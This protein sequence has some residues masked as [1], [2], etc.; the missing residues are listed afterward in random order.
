MG[1]VGPLLEPDDGVRMV[2]AMG[3]GGITGEDE[4]DLLAVFTRGRGGETGR[5]GDG[6]AG[7]VGCC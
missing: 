2:G 1:P 6:G 4:R 7:G 3:L 5:G